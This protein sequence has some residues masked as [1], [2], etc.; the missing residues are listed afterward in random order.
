MQIFSLENTQTCKSTSNSQGLYAVN[1]A[2][3]S[4]WNKTLALSGK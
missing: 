1:L 4:A 2:T 3:E